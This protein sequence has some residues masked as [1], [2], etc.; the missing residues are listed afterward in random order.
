MPYLQQISPSDGAEKVRG[1][2]KSVRFFLWGTLMSV[3]VIIAIYSMDITIWTKPTG[4][5]LHPS[6]HTTSIAEKSF[7]THHP[8]IQSMAYCTVSL[9]KKMLL[10][11]AVA[12]LQFCKPSIVRSAKLSL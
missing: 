8:G 11:N 7:E 2:C 5:C 10:N 1:S 12:L 9:Y 4:W 6:G 3:Q